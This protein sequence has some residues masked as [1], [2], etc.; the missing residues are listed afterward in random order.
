MPRSRRISIFLLF[1]K[2]SLLKYFKY[3]AYRQFLLSLL[4]ICKKKFGDFALMLLLLL[5]YVYPSKITKLRSIGTFF[6]S[7]ILREPAYYYY[8]KYNVFN[9]NLS[10]DALRM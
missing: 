2:I 6:L 7:F 1:V 4:Q 9:S 10:F 5:V 3:F 8:W